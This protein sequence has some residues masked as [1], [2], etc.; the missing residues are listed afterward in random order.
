[1]RASSKDPSS[2][3][4]LA[5]RAGAGEV[6]AFDELARRYQVPLL[7]FLMRF[8]LNRH[9]AEDLLQETFA[10]LYAGRSSYRGRW[11]FR[12]W[13]FS[14]ARHAAIDRH[15]R[16]ARQLPR[17]PADVAHVADVAGPATMEEGDVWS[18]AR[19]HLSGE[20][21]QA[22]WMYHVESI[23][24]RDIAR[25]LGRS[26]VSVRAMLSRGRRTLKSVLEQSRAQSREQSR[27]RSNA[28]A[29]DAGAKSVELVRGV[30]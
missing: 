12:T 8:T 10:R 3:E 14:V 6:V 29:T 11:P 30:P 28:E 5:L 15:R 2:D 27:E 24:P 18:A 4:A 21:V 16:Q 9:D 23:P 17:D 20:Q 7:R 26:W 25:V 13:A 1:M 19:R 22:L